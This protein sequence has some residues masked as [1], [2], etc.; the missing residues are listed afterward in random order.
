MMLGTGPGRGIALEV[1][2]DYLVVSIM[3][4]ALGNSIISFGIALAGIGIWLTDY[5]RLSI[6]K[7]RETRRASSSLPN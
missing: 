3:C 4:E 6:V 2:L 5:N 1:S 7:A